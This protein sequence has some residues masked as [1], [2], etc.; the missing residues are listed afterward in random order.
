MP[1]YVPPLLGAIL[2]LLGL[3]TVLCA[4]LFWLRRKKLQKKRLQSDSAASTVRRNRQ[5]WSWLLGVYGDEKNRDH[6]EDPTPS[7]ET[8]NPFDHHSA[9]VSPM[10]EVSTN[11]MDAAVETQGREVYEMPGALV[12]GFL[13]YYGTKLTFAIA[14]TDS[15]LPQELHSSPIN[16]KRVTIDEVVTEMG[17]DPIP[18]PE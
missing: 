3:I 10:T 14:N 6:F 17:R 1:S 11:P 9:L 13:L 16:T 4:I 2:G 7:T 8:A 15:S 5:T 12:F 18:R